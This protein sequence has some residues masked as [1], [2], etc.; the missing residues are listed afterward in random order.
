MNNFHDSYSGS[1]ESV[2]VAESR[3]VDP[4]SLKNVIFIIIVC[5]IDGCYRCGV[6]SPRVAIVA[7]VVQNENWLLGA[8]FR[9]FICQQDFRLFG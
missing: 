9:L 2:E 8:L 6:T 7:P 1:Q 4:V 3:Y 5:R